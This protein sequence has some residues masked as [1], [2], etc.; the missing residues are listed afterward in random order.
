MFLQSD[1]DNI[2]LLPALPKAWSNGSVSGLCTIYGVRVDIKWM[3]GK[4]TDY[5]VY[6]DEKKY[7]VIDC[8]S[9]SNNGV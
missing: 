6:D 5:T 4:V 7:N 1:R 2:Y 3:D 9:L 8:T